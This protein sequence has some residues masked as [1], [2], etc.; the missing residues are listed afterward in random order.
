LGI[1]AKGQFR[2][3]HNSERPAGVALWALG[4]WLG[5]GRIDASDKRLAAV[6]WKSRT[7][8]RIIELVAP[9]GGEA[10]MLTQI[11]QSSL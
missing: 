9:F 10:A 4:R 11:G 7:N 8:I 2:V 3:L 1:S 5:G 6:E